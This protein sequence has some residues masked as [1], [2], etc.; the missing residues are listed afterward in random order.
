[1][2]FGGCASFGNVAQKRCSRRWH[3]GTFLD[4]KEEDKEM[5]G[6]ASSVGRKRDICFPHLALGC[7]WRCH[8]YLEGTK[9]LGRNGHESPR[10][11]C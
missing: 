10:D 6:V 7:C 1:M 8:R 5:D 11:R 2:V 3:R 4:F 9:I